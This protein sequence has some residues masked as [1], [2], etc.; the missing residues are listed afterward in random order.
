[1]ITTGDFRNNVFTNSP[2]NCNCRFCKFYERDKL[3]C[4]NKESPNYLSCMT[5]DG[6]CKGS[7]LICDEIWLIVRSLKDL[8]YNKEIPM[9]YVP[10]LSPSPE[11]YQKFLEWKSQGKWNNKIFSSEYVPQFLKELS[12]PEAKEAL[13]KLL[14]ESRNKNIMLSC[15]CKDESICHRSVVAGVLQGM[16]AQTYNLADYSHYYEEYK[17]YNSNC[18]D[19]VFYLL[20]AGSRNYNNFREMKEILDKCLEYHRMQGHEIVII[21]G[22]ARGADSLAEK[23]AS[24]NNYKT[25]IIPA[26]WQKYGR[27]AGYVR[28]EQMH[29]KIAIPKE[30]HRGCICFWD[31]ESLGTKHNFKLAYK[32]GTQLR[33]Y[34]Y[35]KRKFLMDDELKPY[36]K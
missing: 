14:T 28:N 10:E 22:G 30:N 33:V 5:A 15:Y 11:L 12:F 18:E 8:D 1:M 35:V 6:T 36:I 23:Y 32:Y 26:D 4:K 31:G 16:G 13:E 20:V 9:M 25:I 3:L 17:K 29:K 24:I 34:D 27:G 19:N 21:S 7:K 2:L